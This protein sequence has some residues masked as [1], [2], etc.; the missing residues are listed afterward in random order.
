MT[1][2]RDATVV[3]SSAEARRLDR[4]VLVGEIAEGGMGRIYLARQLGAAGFEKLMAVKVMLPQRAS[5]ESYHDMFLDEARIAARLV[6]P[7]VCMVFD[8]GEAQGVQYLVMEYLAGQAV[9]EIILALNDHP[10]MRSEPLFH[11]TA[12]RIIADAC[13]GL[14][15]AHVATDDNGEPLNVVHR[16]VSP[17]NVF[18]T[19]DGAVKVMD[20]GI[21][22]AEGRLHE[23]AAGTFKGKVPYASPEGLKLVRL[24]PRADVWSAGVVL[25]ELL[26]GRSC[27][28]R[29]TDMK[30]AIAIL[31]EPI[32]PPSKLAP[33]IPPQLDEITL[34]A[35]TRELDGRY[36]SA[37]DMARA[38]N[39][40][41]V[42]TGEH[43]GT[44]EISDWMRRLFPKGKKIAAETDRAVRRLS[45]SLEAA[46]ELDE[47]SID[48]GLVS[49]V[50]SL[51][52]ELDLNGF[53]DD[54]ATV[55]ASPKARSSDLQGW[56]VHEAP[57]RVDGR[58]D[59]DDSALGART[60]IDPEPAPREPV[61]LG[62]T[63]NI[64]LVVLVL[65]SLAAGI[66]AAELMARGMP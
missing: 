6:H 62:R 42:S 32:P 58:E 24:D 23:T 53:D 39:R 40:F 7:N 38:L 51:E 19:Y 41:A 36:Q 10:E 14:H 2:R 9:M 63:G 66:I 1:E 15:S 55:A 33:N 20:F 47:G 30:S 43:V 17:E 28:S 4:Y 29:K 52:I 21:A 48:R 50:I 8:Y 61:G 45:D 12:A 59:S 31:K 54:A 44:A 37:R 26:T 64:V 34:R 57:T 22:R 16:D 13:E 5:Q 60:E 65:L 11:A 46:P 18:V 35:L 56:D 25:W 3:T 27:F 49:S